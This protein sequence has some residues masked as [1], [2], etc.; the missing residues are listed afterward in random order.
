MHIVFAVANF[1]KDASQLS[2][3][4]YWGAFWALLVGVLVFVAAGFF[5]QAVILKI[6]EAFA[7]SV[8]VFLLST[9]SIN[10]VT[11]QTPLVT[12]A[13]NGSFGSIGGAGGGGAGAGVGLTPEL[14]AQWSK[15][16]QAEEQSTTHPSS[17]IPK[18]VLRSQPRG[19][20]R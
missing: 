19:G 8:A 9:N 14:L 3:V 11:T 5:Q 16:A 15:E 6:L 2:Q 4:V 1:S 13:I 18:R 20:L 7:A 10:W 12:A 17:L